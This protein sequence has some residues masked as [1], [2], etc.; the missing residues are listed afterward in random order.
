MSEAEIRKL[1][2]ALSTLENRIEMY[3]SWIDWPALIESFR[4]EADEVRRLLL[5]AERD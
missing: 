5:E 1:E 2:A 4:R 3:E